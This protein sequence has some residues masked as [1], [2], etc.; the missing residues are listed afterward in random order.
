MAHR[1]VVADASVLLPAFFPEIL[2]Y[3]GGEFDLSRR[4]RPLAA[5]IRSHRVSAFAPEILRH[6]FIDAARK[7]A[8]TRTA[9][10]VISIDAAYKRIDDFLDLPIVYVPGKQICVMAIDLMRKLSLSTADSWY[11]ACAIHT[12]SEFWI[13]HE[14]SDQLVGLARREHEQTYML[15]HTAF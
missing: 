8:D 10:G 7:K 1:R 5:S 14:H 3:Q 13:S 6:E 12:D 15:T 2:L 9:A 4:A 11:L